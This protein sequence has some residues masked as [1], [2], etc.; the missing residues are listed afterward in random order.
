MYKIIHSSLNLNHITKLVSF[1]SWP[2]FAHF[3]FEDL[4]YLKLLHVPV[5]WKLKGVATPLKNFGA[6]FRKYRWE[7]ILHRHMPTYLGLLFLQVKTHNTYLYPVIV[8]LLTDKQE[9][10]SGLCHTIWICLDLILF[11]RFI[12]GK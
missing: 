6:Q 1:E 4:A 8:T 2:H 7:H 9:S 5:M 11:L 3:E 12:S 10:L